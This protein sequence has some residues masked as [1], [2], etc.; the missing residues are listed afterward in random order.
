MSKKK[1]KKGIE[2][3]KKEIDVHRN[4]KLQKAVEED[5]VELASYYEK[6]IKRLEGQLMEKEEK[7]LPRS[8]RLKLK[9]D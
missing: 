8:K 5:K 1:Y 2:S 7:L 4:I 3:L 9:K 6:E